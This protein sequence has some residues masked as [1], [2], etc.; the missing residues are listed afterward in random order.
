MELRINIY[1]GR[2]IEK[3]YTANEYDIMF[4]TVEDLINLVDS[5]SLSE[6]QSDM[7]WFETILTFVRRAMQEIKALVKDIFPDMTDEE[8]K[9]V[10][11]KNL[12]CNVIIAMMS[13]SNFHFRGT[14]KN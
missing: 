10:R 14:K 2:K 13:L 11:T 9:R 4:G 8:F 5:N 1:K 7:E 3:T 12:F 6:K